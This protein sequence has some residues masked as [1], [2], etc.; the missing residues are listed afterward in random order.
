MEYWIELYTKL[1]NIETGSRVD[2]FRLNRIIEEAKSINRQRFGLDFK[3]ALWYINKQ[4]R[5]NLRVNVLKQ[6][7]QHRAAIENSRNIPKP[8]SVISG[9][10]LITYMASLPSDMNN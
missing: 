1:R 9:G 6:R 5:N 7:A 3:Y 2:K 4:F 8:S 10:S